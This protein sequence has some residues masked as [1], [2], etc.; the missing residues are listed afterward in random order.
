MIKNRRTTITLVGGGNSS[1]TIICLLSH[2]GH[3]VNLLTPDAGEWSYN[4]KM[5]SVLDDGTLKSSLPGQLNKISSNPEIV[6]PDSE[7]ILL[8]L[9]VSKYRVVLHEIAPFIRRDKKIYI[10][11]IYGQGGF[12]WMV[13]EI[14]A[15]YQLK[16]VVYFSSGLIPWITRVKEFGK[17]GF[18]YGSKIVNIAAVYPGEGFDE[19]QGL[20]LDDLCFNYFGTGKFVKVDNF[21]SLTL[22]VDNQIVHLPRLYGLYK[23]FGGRWKAL[24]EVPF[25]YLDYDDLSASLME[26]LDEDYTRIRNK[27]RELYPEK[28]FKYMLNY[29]DLE[30]LSHNSSN[31]RIKESL[32]NSKELNQIITPVVQDKNGSW[33]LDKNHRFFKD[34]LYYGLAIS[35]WIGQKLSIDT[36]AIDKII[37]WAQDIVNDTLLNETGIV[38][39][40]SSD[41]PDFK[42]GIPSTYGFS[43]VNETID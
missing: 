9:P 35:K 16:H 26:Q 6:I 18:N 33:I 34:D 30:R 29:I 3:T 24:K 10:G 39:V 14:I 28:S 43:S 32:T 5:E 15:K 25:F 11:T 2:A 36:P 8:G 40:K 12:N 13:E 23:K 31:T 4:V 19:L 27:I 37:L 21:L 20:L 42:Y 38:E 1:Y 17:S 41:N 7:I 22:S